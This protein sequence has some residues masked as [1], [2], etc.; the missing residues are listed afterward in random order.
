[1]RDATASSSPRNPAAGS[2]RGALS[3]EYA[4]LAAAVAGVLILALTSLGQLLS[5]RLGCMTS[6]LRSGSTTGCDAGSAPSEPPLITEGGAG[7]GSGTDPTG[8]GGA[9][10]TGTGAPDVPPTTTPTKTPTPT[11]TP[12][13]PSPSTPSP[14]DPSPTPESP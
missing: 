5:E 6:G 3:V 10:D 12:T 7:G 9:G 2:D 11:P 4:L 13:S 1:V 14:S 8:D